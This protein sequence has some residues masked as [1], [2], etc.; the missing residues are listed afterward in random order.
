MPRPNVNMLAAQVR[1]A[2]LP[3]TAPRGSSPLIH[4]GTIDSADPFR[5]V[6]DF[7]FNHPANPVWGGVPILLPY[8][9]TNGPQQGDIVHMLQL[10]PVGIILGQQV[11][12]TGSV[13]VP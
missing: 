8:S 7:M 13:I 6:A 1:R 11:N 9:A 10:G 2:N 4:I 12:P 3:P 5:N